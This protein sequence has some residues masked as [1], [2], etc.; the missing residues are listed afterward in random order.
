MLIAAIGPGAAL[1][2]SLFSGLPEVWETALN[3]V[4]V[5]AAGLAT[6]LIVRADKTVP[7]V[8]GLAQAILTVGLAAGIHATPVQQAAA[9]TL[10][11]IV[12]AAFVRTQVTA[13]INERGDAV[14]T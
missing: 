14:L 3:A 11:G 13:P 9:M 10:V 12:S 7:A 8:I 1:L 2:L 5:A 4:A 6:A